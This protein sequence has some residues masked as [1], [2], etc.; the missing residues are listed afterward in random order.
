MQGDKAAIEA[1]HL[2]LTQILLGGIKG[3]GIH[4]TR[5]QGLEHAATRHQRNLALGRAT[6]H[7]HGN[8]A[9]TAAI[10]VG[11]KHAH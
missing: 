3:M 1:L 7:K 9:Q 8:L 5:L 11:A 6:T 4:A 10:Y 2:E